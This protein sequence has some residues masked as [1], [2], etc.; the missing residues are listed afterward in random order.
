MKRKLISTLALL[1]MLTLVFAATAI[2][3]LAAEDENAADESV[4]PAASETVLQDG[5][6][7]DTEEVNDSH[8]Y[9]E[10]VNPNATK[11]IVV[12]LF[13]E[14]GK[15]IATTTCK[16][17][18]YYGLDAL[19]VKFCIA[20]DSSSW[21]TQW[22]SIPV[23]TEIPA[24]AELWIDGDIASEAK[25]HL[26]WNIDFPDDVV[27]W[28]KVEGV[29]TPVASVVS[30]DVTTYYETLAG[31][32]EAA[33]SGD[34]VTLL[35]TVTD[36]G[37]IN[38]GDG[39]TLDGQG[40]ELCGASFV[41][42]CKTGESTVK[43]VVFKDI[44]SDSFTASAIYATPKADGM[45]ATVTGC[46]F[47]NVA[48]DAIQ[49]TT[50]SDF[51][52]TATVII[53]DNT[54]SG[55][56]ERAI[57]V[58]GYGH[59][60]ES[61][62]VVINGNKIS[63]EEM[64]DA[65][66]VWYVNLTD[67]SSLAEN[68]VSDTVD[69]IGVTLGEYNSDK[70]VNAAELMLPFVDS[71]GEEIAYVAKVSS[72]EYEASFYESL[73][74]AIAAAKSGATVTLLDNVTV[75]EIIGVDKELT[76][77]GKGFTVT[78]TARKAF[79][80][81]NANDEPIYVTFNN[82]NIINT[83]TGGRC[84]D[85]RNDYIAVVVNDSYLAATKSV[86]TN[87]AQPIT[88]GGYDTEGTVII[89]NGTK[90]EA[91]NA[92][93]AIISFV[94]SMI[95]VNEGSEL[96]G[97]TGIFM[98]EGSAGSMVEVNDSTITATNKV[99][100]KSNNFA[101]IVL[102]DDEIQ[103]ALM[104]ATVNANANSDAKQAVVSFLGHTAELIVDSETV[105]N[106]NGES[107]CVLSGIASGQKISITNEEI[108]AIVNA[109]LAAAGC[110]LDSEGNVV[111]VAEICQVMLTLGESLG[112]QFQVYVNP[113][114]IGNG[115]VIGRFTMN[116]VSVVLNSGDLGNGYFVFG[117]AGIAP[118]YMGKG[119]DVEIIIK[120]EDGTETV[121]TELAGY[122][123]KKNLEYL[124]TLTADELGA[125]SEEQLAALHTLI[126]DTLAYGAAAQKYTDTDADKLVTDGVDVEAS[127]WEEVTETDTTLTE[128]NGKTYFTAA[129]VRFEYVN[130]LYFKFKA[131]DIYSTTLTV[132]DTEYTVDDFISC[133][134][135]VYMIYT[136]EIFAYAAIEG[137]YNV[138]LSDASG[139]TQTLTY[140]IKSYVAA[141]QNDAEMGELAR[142]FYNYCKSALALATMS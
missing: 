120:A 1:L 34:V 20:D 136:D 114:F 26:L 112:M 91:D 61:F 111:L 79:E 108:A 86:G 137:I 95:Q 102:R 141:M 78:A 72:D 15:L 40:N 51:V 101:A 66:G 116:G 32:A 92:A 33:T 134:D 58:E 107:A 81:T 89:L 67:D 104:G 106:L 64:G 42:M 60:D 131:E 23:S 130:R 5:R 87:K 119:I 132:N 53:T 2:G 100:G 8:I 29:I 6:I 105:I 17:P 69:K 39:V 80:I 31:A 11:S 76:F 85:T 88:V 113:E 70:L 125:E 133:G 82:I 96:I 65:I 122:T 12:K 47:V 57:H 90:V 52:G 124:L 18:E 37:K 110:T 9:M 50:A 10:I 14:S 46:T 24:R 59:A 22:V 127:E 99:N 73:V 140:S 84:I 21:D 62:T 48:W 54:F 97:Y 43:N 93:Y 63:S 3:T 38:L 71:E 28:S 19:G 74:D 115:K 75:N 56:M 139:Y 103:V 44:A 98:K 77:E 25:V 55:K 41:Y 45:K 121:V 126:A 36:A 49:S 123:A 138:E 68:Y 109:E 35:T 4:A 13:D 129:G 128:S 30:G 135:G 94:M 142:A 16:K 117:Y 118:Q 7:V 27:D 83:A